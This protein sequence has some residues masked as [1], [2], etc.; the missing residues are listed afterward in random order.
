MLV[1]HNKNWLMSKNI[2]LNVIENTTLEQLII[3]WNQVKVTSNKGMYPD[4]NSI[5]TLDLIK[6][7]INGYTH[8]CNVEDSDSE[9]FY[10]EEFGARTLPNVRIGVDIRQLPL[11]KYPKLACA[12]LQAYE[13]LTVKTSGVPLVQELR[14]IINGNL[15]RYDRIILPLA[16]D[17]IH[18]DKLLVG[19]NYREADF[20][21]IY[22]GS[23]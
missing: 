7:G 16:T 1:Q 23:C 20:N 6:I 10:A 22:A 18:I 12:T 17:S 5:K 11:K 21:T 3:Y 9:N 8:I 4:R 13:F 15:K 2:G 14:G 19:V